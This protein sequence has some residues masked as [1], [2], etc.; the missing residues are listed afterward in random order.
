MS[1]LLVFHGYY[2]V[3]I[4]KMRFETADGL[5]V[6]IIL[7]KC[8]Q[9][10]QQIKKHCLQLLLWGEWSSL[11]LYTKNYSKTNCKYN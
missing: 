7:N 3:R 9:D 4:C 8:Q 5:I 11:E 1:N 6:R 2:G 10:Y